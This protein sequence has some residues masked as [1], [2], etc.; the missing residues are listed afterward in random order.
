[1]PDEFSKPFGSIEWTR[2]GPAITLEDLE[3]FENSYGLALPADYRSFLLEVNGGRPSLSQLEVPQWPG[4][5]STV[6][7]FL[8]HDAGSCGLEFWIQQFDGELPEGGF[9]A[10]AHDA[11][12][13]FALLGTKASYCGQ[14]YYWDSSPDWD[15]DEETGTMFLVAESFTEF[16]SKLR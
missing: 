14:V 3:A 4:R 6:D 7:S 13:N 1:M 9:L 8:R 11:G 12:G 16:L 10:I 5:E 15:L 2:F